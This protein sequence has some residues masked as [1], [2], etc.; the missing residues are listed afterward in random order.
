MNRKIKNEINKQT[1][2]EVSEM[3]NNS[4][5]DNV[6]NL[7][8]KKQEINKKN[9]KRGIENEKSYAKKRN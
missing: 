8:N 7:K 6:D 9:K 5:R 3:K 4:Y 1:K 2:D